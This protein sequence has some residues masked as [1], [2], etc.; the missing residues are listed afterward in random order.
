M[1]YISDENIDYRYLGS[2]YIELE[3]SDHPKVG[4]MDKEQS[5]V[6]KKPH[7]HGNGFISF[8]MAKQHAVP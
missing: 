6:R 2:E 8:G 1:L 5:R 3:S 4:P 7:V